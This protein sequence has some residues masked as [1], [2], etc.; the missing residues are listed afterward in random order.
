[1]LQLGVVPFHH[2]TPTGHLIPTVLE[3]DIC[4]T[5]EGRTGT[6]EYTHG[7]DGIYPSPPPRGGE[8]RR[9]RPLCWVQWARCAWL[10]SWHGKGSRCIWSYWGRGRYRVVLCPPG[11]F[12][13]T[14]GGGGGGS[15]DDLPLDRDPSCA[16]YGGFGGYDSI[17]CF[18][19]AVRGLGTGI[20]NGGTPPGGVLGVGGFEFDDASPQFPAASDILRG[21]SLYSLPSASRGNGTTRSGAGGEPVILVRLRR[22]PRDLISPQGCSPPSAL[23]EVQVMGAIIATATGGDGVY[24]S[25]YT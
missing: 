13:G 9:I 4:T 8:R 11:H 23:V 6:T 14:Y 18:G 20:S 19:G 12:L 24:A 1:M 3:L 5:E 15:Y 21:D 7:H 25:R 16:T 2:R 17:D 22:T 10:R